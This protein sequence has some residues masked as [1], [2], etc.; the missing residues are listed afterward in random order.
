VL[1]VQQGE[2]WVQPVTEVYAVLIAIACTSSTDQPARPPPQSLAPTPAPLHT[3]P[4]RSTR[5]HKAKSPIPMGVAS[6]GPAHA[7]G[8]S[9]PGPLRGKCESKLNICFIPFC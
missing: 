8:P 5:K 6:A 4:P 3:N 1:P 2:A 9:T 7:A